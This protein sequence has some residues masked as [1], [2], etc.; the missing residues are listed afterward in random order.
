MSD[1]VNGANILARKQAEVDTLRARVEQLY[2]QVLE[3]KNAYEERV[4]EIA[5]LK[6]ELKTGH[7]IAHRIAIL[8]E[9]HQHVGRCP[10][11]DLAA[12]RERNTSPEV[13]R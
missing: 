9:G 4:A 2:Q 10:L 1:D 5:A 12:W 3:Y 7:A 6:A 13:R 8:Y 11:C